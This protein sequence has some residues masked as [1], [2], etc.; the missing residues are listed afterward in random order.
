[1]KKKLLVFTLCFTLIF[2]SLNYKKSYAD[3]G[4]LSAP[5]L[6]TVVTVAVGSGVIINSYD[7]IVNIGRI[8]YDCHKD[9]MENVNSIFNLS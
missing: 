1:M 8:F 3:A 4:I 9:N 6:A 2:S 7:D 5:L